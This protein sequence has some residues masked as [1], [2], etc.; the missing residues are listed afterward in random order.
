[1]RKVL[2]L[3]PIVLFLLLVLP[4][5]VSA[6]SPINI[7]AIISSSQANNSPSGDCIGPDKKHFQTTKEVCE[8]LNKAW[9]KKNTTFSVGTPTPVSAPT[10]VSDAVA[11]AQTNNLPTGDCVGPDK[12]HFQ[13]AKEVCEALYKSWGKT[14]VTFNPGVSASQTTVNLTELITQAEKTDAPKGDC[15]GPDKKHLETT[16]EVC[17][18]LNHA[19]GKTTASFNPTVSSSTSGGTTNA[20]GNSSGLSGS[21]SSGNSNSSVSSGGNSGSGST[22]STKNSDKE[23]KASKDKN[24][25]KNSE[26]KAPKDKPKK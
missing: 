1:M 17:D 9:G 4:G 13:A 16:K 5:S 23:D 24:K 7:S 26:D 22:T 20:G 6:A 8:A 14:A 11:L 25:T 15:A 10:T 3:F 21:A 19:W 12:K 18:G 2:P